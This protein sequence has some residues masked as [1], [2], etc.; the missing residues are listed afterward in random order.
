MK[1]LS[2]FLFLSG[3]V[4]SADGRTLTSWVSGVGG[5]TATGVNS[6]TSIANVF[7]ASQGVRLTAASSQFFSL[8]S[9]VN[10]RSKTQEPEEALAN[11][12]R[13]QSSVSKRQG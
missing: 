8:S 7:G 5:I 9:V 10:G 13:A 6:P 11:Y 4:A 12:E 1:R 3:F 2:D